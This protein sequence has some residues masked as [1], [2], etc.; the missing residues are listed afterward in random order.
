MVKASKNGA[1]RY[2][3]A[4]AGNAD[5][6]ES[7]LREMNAEYLIFESDISEERAAKEG[8]HP[9][10]MLYYRGE[11]FLVGREVPWLFLYYAYIMSG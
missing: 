11:N 2:Y 7:K 9:S 10:N 3:K 1:D 5:I 6:V 8:K 4:N